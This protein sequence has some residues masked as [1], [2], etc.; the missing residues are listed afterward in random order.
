[1]RCI[2]M[3]AAGGPDQ[4]SLTQ[5]AVP[6]PKAGEVLIAVH[7]AGVNRPDVAQRQGLYPPPPGASD[8]LGLEVAGEVV[9]L[10]PGVQSPAL[11]EK[12]CALLT[13]GGYA[14]YATAAAIC[15]LPI[16]RGLSFEQAAALP[17]TFF[18]VWHNVFERGGLKA[19]DG[20][21]VHGGTS[22]IG[23][24][25]I[26]LAKAFGAVVFATAGSDEK[27]AACRTLGADLA[28]NYRTTDFVEA[29]RQSPTGG[30]DLVL[31]MVGGAYTARNFRCLKPDGRLV[32][33]AFLEGSKTELD[34][35][36]VLLKRLT[37]TGSTLRPRDVAFKGALAATLK[38]RVWPLLEAGI[39]NP[40]ID[41]IL[42]L[43]AAAEAHL[44][45]E[46][47]VHIGKIVLQV[48]R[49]S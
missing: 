49:N 23:T 6:V 47:S 34:L 48:E 27:V 31:D 24:T 44:R 9:A 45:M 32:N 43:D 37:L 3:K 18:T 46:S 39:V 21:L 20:F 7:A 15:C 28:I 42:P 11:G 22:G 25:A 5:R 1:M 41:W 33:I 36:P 8:I 16:P 38:S 10:G 2:E 35:M 4:L 12:V 13:G 17:E 29:V 40:V 30:V 26:Q 14:E 19:G